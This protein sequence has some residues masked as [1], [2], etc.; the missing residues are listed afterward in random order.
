M[1]DTYTVQTPIF[2]GPFDLLLH[3]IEKRKLF[4]GDLSLA[5]VTA[6]YIRYLRE[7]GGGSITDV[8][9]FVSIASTLILIKSKSLLPNLQISKEEEEDVADLK[10]RLSLYKIFQ[11][12]S[13]TL[14]KRYGKDTIYFQGE[15]NEE[16]IVFSPDASIHIDAIKAAIDS[17]LLNI[18]DK[19]EKKVEISIARV[20]SIDEMISSLSDRIAHSI[21]LTFKDFSNPEGKYESSKEEKVHVIV[22]FLA[23]LELAREG[24]LALV[25]DNTFD[26]ILITKKEQHLEESP[27]EDTM[28]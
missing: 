15:R 2:Q 25:Q 7:S 13:D 11:D 26:D 20:M 28:E 24:I 18:P 22:S 27:L 19:K 16:S 3:L 10:Q 9:S 17:V 23:V 12:I 1:S 4:I 21:S 6:D 8:S 5:E 14:R